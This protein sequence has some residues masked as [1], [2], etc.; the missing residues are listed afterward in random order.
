MNKSDTT[1]SKCGDMLPTLYK[2]KSM[3]QC[4]VE[5]FRGNDEFTRL[6]KVIGRK[7]KIRKS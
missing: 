2:F 5:S 4:Y 7:Y 6:L 1:L 3:P